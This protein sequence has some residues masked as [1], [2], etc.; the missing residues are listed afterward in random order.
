MNE[1]AIMEKPNEAGGTREI[2]LESV[3]EK[4]NYQNSISRKGRIKSAGGRNLL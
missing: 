2:V 3:L 4:L 1:S